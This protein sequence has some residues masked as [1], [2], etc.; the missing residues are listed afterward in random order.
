MLYNKTEYVLSFHQFQI[1]DQTKQEMSNRISAMIFGGV[2]IALYTAV[3]V[4]I[5]PL[6]IAEKTLY[7]KWL[8][9][10]IFSQNN[11]VI[12]ATVFCKIKR[13]KL[14]LRCTSILRHAHINSFSRFKSAH[15]L[16]S[17]QQPKKIAIYVEKPQERPFFI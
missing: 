14:I 17:W 11:I 1:S 7:F 12:I 10:K 13:F 6:Q 5:A 4:H 16:I 3:P 15:K 2:Y 8:W 9:W